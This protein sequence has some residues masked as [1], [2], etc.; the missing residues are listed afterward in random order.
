[1]TLTAKAL[2]ENAGV[3]LLVM[4][5]VA[6]ETGNADVAH[7]SHQRTPTHTE[8][9]PSRVVMKRPCKRD[10]PNGTDQY[11][12]STGSTGRRTGQCI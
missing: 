8:A 5:E 2:A 6:D 3:E 7:L 9:Q 10:V 1:M 11:G 4:W 12:R